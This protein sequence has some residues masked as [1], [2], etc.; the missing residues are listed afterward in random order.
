[1]GWGRIQQPSMR[2]Q[3]KNRLLVVCLLGVFVIPLIVAVFLNSQWIDWRPGSTQNYGRLVE[4]PAELPSLDG[5]PSFR[6][7]VSEQRWTVLFVSEGCATPCY[8]QLILLRQVHR[9]LGRDTDR[10]RRVLVTQTAL[11]QTTRQQI[12]H[13]IPDLM[14]VE[15]VGTQWVEALADALGE[16][17]RERALIID[18]RGT[19]VL[20]Y[21][22]TLEGSGFRKDLSHLLKWSR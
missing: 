10:V 22:R 2:T 1:M 16:N 3:T 20:S 15:A 13:E 21:A 12:T 18:P 8:E 19:I 5:L 6:T 11:S 14:T 4:P 17:P 9:T 7:E